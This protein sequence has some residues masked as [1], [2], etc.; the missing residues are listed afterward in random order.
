MG[1]FAD[2]LSRT[3]SNFAMPF[4]PSLR[5]KIRAQHG[6]IHKRMGLRVN[7][8]KWEVPYPETKSPS[9]AASRYKIPSTRTVG[10]VGNPSYKV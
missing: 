10:T 7:G 6:R 1:S 2:F 5:R 4:S 8:K 3:T 9:I